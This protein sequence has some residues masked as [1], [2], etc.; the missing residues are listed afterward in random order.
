MKW[1][2]MGQPLTR[3]GEGEEDVYISDYGVWNETV[4]DEEWICKQKSVSELII[5]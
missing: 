5:Y 4:K 2:A 1:T 3:I